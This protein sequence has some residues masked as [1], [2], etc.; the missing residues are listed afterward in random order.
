[1]NLR[2][3]LSLS[4]I[5]LAGFAAIGTGWG[6][7]A[8]AT[9]ALK[10]HLSLSEA[11]LGQALFFGALG[12]VFS[13]AMAPRI[14][15]W[16]GRGRG[17]IGAAIVPMALGFALIGQAHSFVAFAL[18]ICLTGCA[19]GFVDVIINARVS[20]TEARTGRHLMSLNHGCFSLAYAGAAFSMGLGRE[21]GLPLPWLYAAL[22]AV[23]VLWVLL[24]LRD[25][26][27]ED[28]AAP[29]TITAPSAKLSAPVYLIGLMI[30]TAFFAENSTEIWAALHIEQ[31]L[32]GGAAQGALGPTMLGLTMAF[33]RF[34]GQGLAN[35]FGTRIVMTA[36]ALLGA[37]GGI[38]AAFAPSPQ[39][40][41]LGFG[42]LGLGIS[43]LAPLAFNLGGRYLNDTNRS[44]GIARMSLIGYMGFFLGP[45][46]MGLLAE[47]FG[48]RA[49][50]ALIAGT[51]ALLPLLLA[52][53][54]PPAPKP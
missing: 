38:T 52:Q 26:G 18:A 1:M 33:G 51:I 2:N 47:A 27:F 8:A 16:T 36:M 25:P 35:R 54:H 9:P 42:L 39:I 17:V 49:A 37:A 23:V 24:T 28:T 15:A 6:G 30:L 19:T 45:P 10:Q 29:D 46:L 3:D 7:F 44:T 32:G 50:F 13:M 14:I 53:L 11:D 4:R 12:A 20:S 48:L 41:Y 22:G 34:T 31:T 43:S 5:P 40:A 21:A